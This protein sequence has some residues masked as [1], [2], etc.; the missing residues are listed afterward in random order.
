V[1]NIDEIPLHVRAF[2]EI[3]PI[4]MHLFVYTTDIHL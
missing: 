1:V 3:N 2:S 4:L